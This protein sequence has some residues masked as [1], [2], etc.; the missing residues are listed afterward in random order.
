M[1][2]AA[3]TKLG[4]YEIIAPIGAGGMGEVYR[5]RDTRLDRTV[6]IKVLPTNLSE[7]TQLKQ[8]FEREARTISSLSHPHICALHDIGHQNGIDF[9]V[10]EFLEGESL[11][12]KLQRGALPSDQV[13]RF[14]IEIA[15]ALDKAHR[16]GII[17]RDLK[18]G[19]VIITRSGAKLLD[20][21]LAKYSAVKNEQPGESILET[22]EPLTEAGSLIGTVQYMSPEQLEGKEADERTDIFALGELLYEMATG[23]RTFVGNSK[24]SL[25]SAILTQD[26]PPISTMQPL[27]PPALDH[28]IRK[29]LSKD[30]EER[31]QSAYDVASEL[32][33]ISE[34]GSQPRGEPVAQQRRQKG[35]LLPWLVAGLLFLAA[36]AA[37]YGLYRAKMAET[38]ARLVKVSILPEQD[39]VLNLAGSIAISPDGQYLAFVGIT[40]DG[41]SSLF[42]RPLDSLDA[43]KLPGTEDAVYPFWSPDSNFVGFFAQG[44][45]KKIDI[46]GGP[47]QTLCDASAGRGAAWN[48]AGDILFSPTLGGGIYRISAAGGSV[49]PVTT[50]DPA[51]QESTHRWPCFL[52]DGEHFVYVIHSVSAE[53]SGIFVGALKS[54][55]KSRLL[56][57]ESHAEYAD[58]GYL[59]FVREAN[60]MVQSFDASK[61]AT[62]GEAVPVAEGLYF[63]PSAGAA[64]ISVSRNGILSY[65]TSAGTQFQQFVWYDRQGK[66]LERLGEPQI[67]GDPWLSPDETKLVHYNFRSAVSG[68]PDIWIGDLKQGTFSRFTFDPANEFSPIWSPDGSQ[69]LF[70]SNRKGSYDLYVK[71]V[72]GSGSEKPLFESKDW[73]FPDDWSKDG[74][75]I[76]FENDG[77]K[78]KADLWLLPLFGDRKARPLLQNDF[79]EAQGRLSPNGKWIAYGSDE[80]GRS[81]V[82]VQSFPVLGAKRQVSTG[83]GAQP[84]WSADQKEIYYM[85]PDGR[86]MAVEITSNGSFEAG[87]PT[88]LFSTHVPQLPLVGN[89]RNQYVVTRDSQRFLINRLAS[90]GV[91][92]PITVVFNWT[93]L[94]RK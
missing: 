28:V 41:V 22:R 50:L 42:I 27:A 14:G 19:N 63:E 59:I 91:A 64:S 65:A 6:A 71:D 10:M 85:A 37:G 2:L 46:A 74:K 78:T 56:P 88:P 92:T 87:V 58:P 66:E 51:R 18:P 15:E 61:L 86:L 5:A 76:V 79:N 90:E 25:M 94:L 30:P 89:D 16:Q 8:R 45:L 13:L 34:S 80:T 72:S 62:S 38:P 60:L 9:L 32:K 4:P 70:A 36:L 20:F 1:P 39:T 12:M 52:P 24:A 44:K 84:C 53:N 77:D 82:Y 23:R 68:K 55:V 43:R 11:G 67:L 3:G 26:P 40:K 75:Y 33:W 49:T 93:K 21:G 81:E 29:C 54:K 48:A 35:T 83:G 7:N 57:D 69:I 47:P 17:H 31:W 73:K